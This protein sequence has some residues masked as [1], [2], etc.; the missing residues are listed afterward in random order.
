[1]RS[2]STVVALLIHH[3]SSL[4]FKDT[5]PSSAQA[6][7]L[8][9]YV[10][11]KHSLP[12]S[13]WFVQC[14]KLPLFLLLGLYAVCLLVLLQS[15]PLWLDE[16]LNVIASTKPTLAGLI[17]YVPQNSGA[18]PLGYLVQRLSFH[19]FGF[20]EFSARI[21]SALSSVAA[22]YGVFVLAQRVRLRSPLGAVVLF[23]ILPMQ[24]RYALEGRPYAMA[25]AL[26]IWSCVAFLD[27]IHGPAVLRCVLYSLVVTAALYTNPYASFVPMA[28]LAWVLWHW[29]AFRKAALLACAAN[30]LAALLFLPWFLYARHA[31]IVSIPP[32]GHT[33]AV[34]A[35]ELIA[36]ELVGA[37]YLG[38][39]L[40]LLLAIAGWRK[41]VSAD[42]RNAS[43]LAACVLVPIPLILTGNAVFH[44]FLAARQF[45]FVLPPLCLLA[46]TG[47]YA[48]R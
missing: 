14:P 40:L 46:A 6:Q 23:C 25:L 21:P 41:Q 15:L 10:V 13:L 43:F 1:M 35:A 16:I 30:V 45:I 8:F 28:H 27:L 33:G 48:H 39:A 29:S 32:N 38:T 37:G 18:V 9:S 34:K 31:W 24:W 11:V 42:A 4:I 17:Q 47:L 12:H 22:A 7:N 20:S 36:R 19:L 2:D 26:T 3:F 44:Y 5:G